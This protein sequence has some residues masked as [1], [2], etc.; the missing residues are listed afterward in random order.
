[1]LSFFS[2]I[3]ART[4]SSLIDSYGSYIAAVAGGNLDSA[5]LSARALFDPNLPSWS[6]IKKDI[7]FDLAFENCVLIDCRAE[8]FDYDQ[9]LAFVSG[10][11]LSRA[12][13]VE[14]LPDTYSFKRRELLFSQAKESIY[15]MVWSI[16]DDETGFEFMKQMF[17]ALDRNPDIDIRIMVDG[18]VATLKGH[19]KFLKDL[20]EL[21]DG[22]IK[23]LRWKTHKYRANGSHRK[24]II[25]D[26][27]HVITGGINIGNKY[28]HYGDSPKW[29]DLDIYIQGSE[30]G[31]KAYNQFVSVWNTHD[32]KNPNEM[33][34]KMIPID[35]NEAELPSGLSVVFVDQHPGSTQKKAHMGV[36]TAVVKLLRNARYSVDIENAYFILDP[37]VK[38]EIRDAIKRGV[39]VR[40]FT[41]SKESIDMAI[42]A[43]PILESA[44]K[45]SEWGAEVYLKKG[46]TLHSKFMIVDGIMSMIGSF[47]FHPRSLRFDGENAAIIKDEKLAKSLTHHF[48]E[49]INFHSYKVK[50]PSWIKISWD[51]GAAFVQQFYSDFL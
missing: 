37:V 2:S 10:G 18:N 9:D 40:I 26:K 14:L 38:H 51:A 44:K 42:V 22:K 28:A 47:N 27:K 5:G 24:M 35:L 6:Q 21:S 15:I 32:S 48:E 41:N 7:H 17:N 43:N 23:I 36:H 30:A 4:P 33:R 3:S 25:V 12:D 13:H 8:G 45:A 20:E 50:S 49:G 46:T 39:K 29:R 19:R 34:D 16:Y 1:M 31:Q 11:L